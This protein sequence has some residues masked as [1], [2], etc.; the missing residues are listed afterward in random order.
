MISNLGAC[1]TEIIAICGEENGAGSAT[2]VA[3]EGT[4]VIVID[5]DDDKDEEKEEKVKNR[6]TETDWRMCRGE[7]EDTQKTNE[8]AETWE[9]S[10]E[11]P[12]W[13]TN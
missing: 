6:L 12:S 13:V 8:E 2:T 11:C 3:V 10:G 4:P 5:D 7:I 9:E 1:S